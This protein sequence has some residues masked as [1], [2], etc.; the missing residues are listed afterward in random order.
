MLKEDFITKVLPEKY[1]Q[2]YQL[3]HYCPYGYAGDTSCPHFGGSPG[4][5]VPYMTIVEPDHNRCCCE[6][7]T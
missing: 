6:V 7:P 4:S 3:I 1:L 5:C 2:V